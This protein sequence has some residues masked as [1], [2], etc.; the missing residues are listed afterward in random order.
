MLC[1]SLPMGWK[2]G[3]TGDGNLKSL[4]APGRGL[5]GWEVWPFRSCSDLIKARGLS[6]LPVGGT[7]RPSLPSEFRWEF[8]PCTHLPRGVAPVKS[9][10]LSEP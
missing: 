6:L 7:W 9:L 3:A 2:L 10:P 4:I 8:Q 1:V 5:L